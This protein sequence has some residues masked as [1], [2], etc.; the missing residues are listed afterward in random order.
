MSSASLILEIALLLL[1]A[2]LAGC[3]L[4]WLARRLSQRRRPPTSPE[5]LAPEAAAA[6][7]LVASPRVSPLFQR[8]PMPPPARRELTATGRPRHPPAPAE[9]QTATVAAS[10]AIPVPAASAPVEAPASP[11]PLRPQRLPARVAGELST[12]IATTAEPASAPTV[13]PVAAPSPPPSSENDAE[14]AARQAVEGGWTPPRRRTPAPFPEASVAP[15][16]FSAAP[17]ADS[18]DAAMAGA[19]SAVA[20]ARAAT[21]AVL[22]GAPAAEP[23]PE[24]TELP[25]EPE[26]PE[27]PEAESAQPQRPPLRRRFGAPPLLE[28]PREGG[29]DD[30]TAIRGITPSLAQALNGLGI[31]H[32]DQIA[33][34]DGKAVVWVDGQL[35]LRGRI[36]REKWREQARRLVPRPVRARR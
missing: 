36:A 4:G 15:E 7:P 3:T 14:S 35:G 24:A 31:F 33:G 22:A 5:V 17:S 26:P 16:I 2:F 1:V 30:L 9:N 34:W 28:T 20:A 21:D 12:A 19:R 8:P 13:Q 23:P 27:S 32:H 6:P 29:K 25:P 18:V 10:A 11:T